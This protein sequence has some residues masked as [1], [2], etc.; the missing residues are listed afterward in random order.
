MGLE[1][2]QIVCTCF[3]PA[4]ILHVLFSFNSHNR[5]WEEIVVGLELNDLPDVSHGYKAAEARNVAKS[6]VLGTSHEGDRWHFC[7][8][9]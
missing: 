5:G 2:C 9:F 3:V 4:M 1:W 8:I 6:P 7:M